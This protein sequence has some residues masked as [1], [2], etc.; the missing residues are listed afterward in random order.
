[1][2]GF[3]DVAP[4]AEVAQDRLGFKI[5]HPLARPCTCG[6]PHALQLLQ[7]ADGETA[8]L[9]IVDTGSSSRRSMIAVDT[10]DE[11]RL[12]NMVIELFSRGTAAVTI[13]RTRLRELAERLL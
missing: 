10:D 2:H 8:R 3:D 12:R 1:V 13:P 11:N 6:E 9:R 5:D 7:T 4:H